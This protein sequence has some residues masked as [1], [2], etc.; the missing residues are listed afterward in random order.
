MARDETD[1]GVKVVDRRRLDDEGEDRSVAAATEAPATETPATETPA[2][3]TPASE[4]PASEAPTTEAPATETPASETA[5]SP[6][7]DTAPPFEGSK[8]PEIDF[9]AFIESLAQQALMHLGV[10]PH[11]E[12]GERL[13]ELVLARQTID[14]LQVLHAKTQGNLTADEKQLFDA[15]LHDLRLVFVQVS[16]TPS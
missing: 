15:V 11:P 14:I 4:A 6:T 2:T 1:H 12:T 7:P 13:R 10:L 3:E 16:Q 9:A 8:L 5:E